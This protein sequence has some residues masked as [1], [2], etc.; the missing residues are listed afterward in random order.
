MIAFYVGLVG[1]IA[2]LGVLS[3]RG[4]VMSDVLVRGVAEDVVYYLD[5]YRR[6][7]YRTRASL[8]REILTKWVREQK[9]ADKLD[10]ADKAGT[11]ESS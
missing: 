1:L 11:H 2:K 5:M 4:V 9:A 3:I 7:W 8:I 10:A 6:R